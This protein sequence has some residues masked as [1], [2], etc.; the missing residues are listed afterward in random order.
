VAAASAKVVPFKK[1]IPNIGFSILCRDEVHFVCYLQNNMLKSAVIR[2]KY[3]SDH[4]PLFTK[5][6][7]I[8]FFKNALTI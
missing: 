3:S 6:E 1:M 4:M 5:I 8:T 2:P 7:I